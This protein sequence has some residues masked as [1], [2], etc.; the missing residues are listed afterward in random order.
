MSN[1]A[2]ITNVVNV[3]LIPEGQLAE[4]DSMNLIAVFTSEQGVI[5][6]AERFRTYRDAQAVAADWGSASAVTEYANTVF[7][8]K[9]NAINFGGSLIVALPRTL[10]P[11]RPPCAALSWSR[12]PC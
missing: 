2:S 6:S 12:L 8:T 3:A 7:G 9:P 11:R 4:R 1:N 5:T 10:G